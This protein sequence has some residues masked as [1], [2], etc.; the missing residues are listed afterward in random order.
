MT[1]YVNHHAM[2]EVFQSLEFQP[3][4]VRRS[5]M[6]HGIQDDFAEHLLAMLERTA[7]ELKERGWSLEQIAD[8]LHVPISRVKPLIRDYAKRTNR[9]PPLRDKSSLGTVVDIRSLVRR[10]DRQKSAPTGRPTA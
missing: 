8:E 1:S 4:P 9:V 3:D 2:R 6:M 7:F 10:A 5:E